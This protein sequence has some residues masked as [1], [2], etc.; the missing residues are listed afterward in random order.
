MTRSLRAARHPARPSR[1]ADRLPLKLAMAAP[2]G[3]IP[4]GSAMHCG[5][6]SRLLERP[7]RHLPVRCRID[8]DKHAVIVLDIAPR[9]DAYDPG[10]T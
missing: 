8:E 5:R 9:A 7:P 6:L 4:T 3:T 1:P 10:R 2:C